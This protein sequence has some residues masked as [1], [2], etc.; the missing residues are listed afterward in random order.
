MAVGLVLLSGALALG[1]LFFLVLGGYRLLSSL[2][3]E[4]AAALSMSAI[5]FTLA[6]GVLWTALRMSR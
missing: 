6:G 2:M 5:I 1:G 4:V 3:G